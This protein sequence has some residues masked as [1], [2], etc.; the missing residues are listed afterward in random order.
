[1]QEN[2]TVKVLKLIGIAIMAICSI[3]AIIIG[4]ETTNK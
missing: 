4:G 2:T 1:M 3:G